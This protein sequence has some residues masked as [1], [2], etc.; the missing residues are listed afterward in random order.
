MNF[1]KNFNGVMLF[2]GF[3][4]SLLIT[5]GIV[6]FVTEQNKNQKIELLLNDNLNNL[7]TH[8]KVILDYQQKTADAI[9]SSTI[10]STKTMKILYNL[11][12]SDKNKKDIIRNELYN[13]LKGKYEI[14]KQKGVLQYHFMLPD[15]ESFLRMHKPKK[16]GDNLSEVR[17][18][19]KIVNK[20]KNNIRGF[21]QGRT[22]H[23]FRNTY[24]LINDK[25]VH[26]GVV[27]VSFSSESIQ[28][29]L[30]KI[31][32]IH[33]HFLV[34]KEI[35]DSKTW[36]RDDLV[37]K[38]SQSSENENLMI[39]L[40][41]N[42][43]KD[44][45]ITQNKERLKPIYDDLTNKLKLGKKFSLFISDKN[46]VNTIISFYPIKNIYKTKTLAWLVSYKES[47]YLKRIIKDTN[48]I[49][50]IA[51]I[52]FILIGLSIVKNI[53]SRQKI[54]EDH[55]LLN[56]IISAT[57]DIMF[58]TNFSNVTYSNLRF[59]DFFG[60]KNSE[61]FNNTYPNML[62]IFLEADGYL[63]SKLLKENESFPELILRTEQ[64]DRIVCLADKSLS[65]I[66]FKINASKISNNDDYNFLVTLSD[67]TKLKEKEKIIQQ[68]AYIDR[69]TQVYN[70]NKFEDII[71]SEI[72]RAYRYKQ[73]LSIAILDIDNFKIFNDTYGHLIGD[74]VLIMI[75]K[76]INSRV[77]DT[78][79]FARWGGE[80]FV[81]L[82]PETT[83]EEAGIICE[84]LRLSVEKLTHK[85]AGSVTISF[86]VTQYTDNDSQESLFERCDNAL[87]QSKENGRNTVTVI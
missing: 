3:V 10:K 86:G 11:H 85:T 67:V 47:N 35:F 25:G 40:T 5:I 28:R 75:A 55:E 78:D 41:E 6:Y 61:D 37:L 60:I 81:I 53:L 56:N 36:E 18:D 38:Y 76:E 84:K 24:P 21:T 34:N 72:K 77:R 69:L 1:F 31:S 32:K 7:E 27:E 33:T 82:F 22:A 66:S 8:F 50:F 13:H 63:N 54:R 51:I 43:N 45:C 9:Y 30:T 58:V 19:V 14:V 26:L 79:T 57:N 20:T 68:K 23:G 71:K 46:S 74:E 70:R 80:E 83:K 12:N 59:L 15:N 49:R 29:N 65:Q 48:I 2:L 62:K 17:E 39:T 4:I 52:F 44:I 73:N 42:H 16:F 64:I 87:Y